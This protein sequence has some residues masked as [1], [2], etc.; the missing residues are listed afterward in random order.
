MIKN[1]DT[2]FLRALAIVLIINSHLKNYYPMPYFGTGGAIGNSLFF[3]LSGFGL[4]LSQQEYNKNFKEWYTHRIERIYPSLWIVLILLYMPVMIIEGK[5]SPSTIMT[6]L[7]YFFYP[8]YFFIQ[9]ILIYYLLG[10]PLLKKSRETYIF[11]TSFVLILIYIFW[12]LTV[13]DLSKF[14][15]EDCPNDLI[16]YFVIFLFGIFTASRKKDIIYSNGLKNYFFLFFFLA[17]FYIHKFFM[18]KGLFL[19]YQFMQQAIIYPIVYNLLKISRS[20]LVV[21]KLMGLPFFSKIVE[22]LAD[23]SLEIYLVHLTIRSSI[24]IIGLPFPSNILIFLVITFLLVV[25]I[26]K[27]SNATRRRFL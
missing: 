10:F 17:F 19:E 27:I 26:N 14:S 1:P 25:L 21:T 22:F 16:H 18:L 12:Y 6:F 2:Q 9:Y 4:F 13:V 20:P 15:V 23:N 7:G 3:F 24:L 5:L 11:I 8:P